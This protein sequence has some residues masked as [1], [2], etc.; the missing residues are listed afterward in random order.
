MIELHLADAVRAAGAVCDGRLEGRRQFLHRRR[1]DNADGLRHGS[2][3][4]SA[5]DPSQGCN[6]R[7][8]T[9]EV[10]SQM[11]R[12]HSAELKYLFFLMSRFLIY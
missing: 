2:P 1:A 6:T 10:S 5:G 9:Q 3:S 12:L 4:Q 11:R 7:I 8:C